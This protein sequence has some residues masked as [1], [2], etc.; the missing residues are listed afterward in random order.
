MGKPKKRTKEFKLKQVY[1]VFKCPNGH[2]ISHRVEIVQSSGTGKILDA[3][4]FPV[5]CP[6]CNWEGEVQGS[7]RVNLLP[8]GPN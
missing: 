3:I 4:K 5:R 7:Q 6:E 8:A 1:L 2:K